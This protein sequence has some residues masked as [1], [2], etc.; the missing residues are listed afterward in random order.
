MKMG[1]ALACSGFAAVAATVPPPVNARTPPMG[2]NTW[3]H[4]GG[5]VSAEILLETADAFIKTGL[6]DA[7]YVFINSDDGWLDQNRTIDGK[8][9]ARSDKFPDGVKAVSD[10][11]HGKGFHFGI[12]GA[13]GMTTCCNLAGS[14]YHEWDDA[15]TYAEWGVDYL[16]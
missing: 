6:R 11:L 15:H 1:F 16:K 13:A 2:F 9:H 14:L 12:Y 10:G 5:S 8:L 4:Y 3:N 7:G